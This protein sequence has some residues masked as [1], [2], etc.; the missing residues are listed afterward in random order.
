MISQYFENLIG[1]IMEE[2]RFRG[3]LAMAKK[4]FEEVAGQLM[5][6]DRSFY[7][8]INAFHNWYVLDRTMAKTGK[9]PLAYYLEFNANSIPEDAAEGYRELGQ[10]VN[11]LFKLLK[12]SR[13]RA[14]VRDMM[15][16]K[17]HVVDGAEQLAF[18]E[19]G[20]LFNTRV[21]KHGKQ[22]YLTN[23]L[24]LHPLNVSKIIRA[25]ARKVRK[26]GRDSR[27]FLNRLL[28]FHSRWEQFTQM[29]LDKIYRFPAEGNGNPDV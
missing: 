11:S 22:E 5:E 1:A 26:S 7:A 20:D 12:I 19:R 16:R 10:N 14:Y 28:F 8:R 15:S 24:I 9:T 2:D 27:A 6:S 17:K 29:D 18:L 4:E 21:F 23:Y 3:E 25:E 13:D